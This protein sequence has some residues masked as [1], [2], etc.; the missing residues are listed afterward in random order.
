MNL[1]EVVFAVLLLCAQNEE[2]CII[3]ENIEEKRVI[4]SICDQKVSSGLELEYGLID[5]VN[6]DE[7]VLISI[8][9][10]CKEF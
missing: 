5:V 9:S 6:P 3:N 1:L 7:N 4:I 8:D 2:A 10:N